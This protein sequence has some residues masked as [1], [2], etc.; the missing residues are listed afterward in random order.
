MKTRDRILKSAL[1]LFNEEGEPSVSTV[2]IANEVGISPG[3]LY[4]HFRGKE[5]LIEALFDAFEEELHIVLEAPVAKPLSVE[6]NWLYLYVVFEEIYD[7]R[8]FYRN[9]SDLLQRYPQLARRFRDL[10]S[11]KERALGA[12]LRELAGRDFIH[13]GEAEHIHLAER[14][15]LF[16][17]YWMNDRAVRHPEEDGPDLIHRGVFQMLLTIGA[18]VPEGREV[19]LTL[20]EGFYADIAAK[21]RR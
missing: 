21:K 19:F 9:L 11:L 1:A 4:Y 7:F 6:D 10:L 15:T 12:L 8:F 5:V 14:L 3:N 13:L 20:V 2:D 17:T 16:M 18:Y